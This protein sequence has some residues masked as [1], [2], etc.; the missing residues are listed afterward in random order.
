MGF[1][2]ERAFVIGLRQQITDANLNPRVDMQLW[3]LAGDDALPGLHRCDHQ[4]EELRNPDA[5]FRKG[6]FDVVEV[7]PQHPLI[8][9]FLRYQLRGFGFC[10]TPL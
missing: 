2:Q 8:V 6:H 9:E 3:L 1:D 7:V 4:R 5:H 10:S